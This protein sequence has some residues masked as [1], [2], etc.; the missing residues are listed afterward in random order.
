MASSFVYIP[1][2]GNCMNNHTESIPQLFAYSG[3]FQLIL[4]S[5]LLEKASMVRN[6][7]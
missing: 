4:V 2:I 6:K 3:S 7:Q 1:A 5:F